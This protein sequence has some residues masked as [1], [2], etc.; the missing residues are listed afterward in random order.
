MLGPQVLP[1][2]CGGMDQASSGFRL[3]RKTVAGR[4]P[5]QRGMQM[6]KMEDGS[7]LATVGAKSQDAAARGR[8]VLRRQR[9]GYPSDAQVVRARGPAL[10]APGLGHLGPHG[11]QPVSPSGEDSAS[12]PTVARIQERGLSCAVGNGPVTLRGDKGA[13]AAGPGPPRQRPAQH[14]Q[15]QPE[16]WRL[17][18]AALAHCGGVDQ[19]AP[20]STWRRYT[21]PQDGVVLGAVP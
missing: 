1:G 8:G 9:L 13:G 19:W 10:A 5:E 18:P 14:G 7:F 2:V 12:L 4:G 11:T 20:E 16:S 15:G 6:P 17:A 21:L 3:H